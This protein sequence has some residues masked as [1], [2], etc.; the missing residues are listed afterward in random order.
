MF[1]SS[2]LIFSK[3]IIFY[4]FIVYSLIALERA[5]GLLFSSFYL[6]I[7]SLFSSVSTIM[8]SFLS[9]SFSLLRAIVSEPPPTLF[10]RFCMI[11][12]E[13]TFFCCEKSWRFLIRDEVLIGWVHS[14]GSLCR[15]HTVYMQ[16]KLQSWQSGSHTS[17]PCLLKWRHSWS[18]KQ[19]YRTFYSDA[20]WPWIRK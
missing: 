2:S 18:R 4:L 1:T 16:T 3:L 12:Y 5:E 19:V 17:R 14:W 6:W 8:Y 15:K 10:S 7:F 11:V 13:V 9:L 20:S